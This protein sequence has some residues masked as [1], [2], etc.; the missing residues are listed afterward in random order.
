MYRRRRHE[1]NYAAD[2][3]RNVTLTVNIHV[4]AIY[5]SLS[6]IA[7]PLILYTLR[8]WPLKVAGWPAWKEVIIIIYDHFILTMAA[9]V[10]ECI[11]TKKAI[12]EAQIIA[13][14]DSVDLDALA[15][16]D[17]SLATYM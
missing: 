13:S 9:C 3:Q 15:T 5:I 17:V 1:H 10:A 16:G 8:H 7:C 6:S 12:Y 4:L 11:V 2:R 14:C